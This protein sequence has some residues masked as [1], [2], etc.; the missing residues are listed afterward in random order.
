MTGDFT[1]QTTTWRH[2][3]WFKIQMVKS[4]THSQ[5]AALCRQSSF[6]PCLPHP[7]LPGLPSVGFRVSRRASGCPVQHPT[8]TAQCVQRRWGHASWR[9]ET[10]GDFL[11][12]SFSQGP[13]IAFY[14]ISFRELLGLIPPRLSVCGCRLKLKRLK[15]LAWG[16]FPW[17]YWHLAAE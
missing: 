17:H 10:W 14:G 15:P 6:R 12:F 16:F 4:V 7:D 2:T 5:W 9:R 3:K 11:C 1:S 13:F 8:C